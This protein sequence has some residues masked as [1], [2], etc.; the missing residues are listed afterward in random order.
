MEN[1]QFHRATIMPKDGN[2]KFSV[3][4]LN[5]S[6]DFEINEGGSVAVSGRIYVPEDVTKEQLD[7]PLPPTTKTTQDILSLQLPDVYKDLRYFS[8]CYIHIHNIPVEQLDIK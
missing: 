2:V 8:Y 4:I 5:G 7:L 6:G 1:L 3:N